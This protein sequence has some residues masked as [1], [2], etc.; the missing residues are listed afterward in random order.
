MIR[1]AEAKIQ[2]AE[3][4]LTD[5]SKNYSFGKI[6]LNDYIDAVN[7]VDLNRF[8]KILHIVQMKKYLL[9]WFALN[10]PVS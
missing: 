7:K 9:E 2:L 5:E 10:R 1:I 8:N 4:V 6:S 3:A